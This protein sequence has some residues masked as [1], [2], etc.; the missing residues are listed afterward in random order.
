MAA[1]LIVSL[2]VP[3]AFGQ[4][5]V[6]FGVAYFV[7]R[8]LLLALYA[9]AA[10]GDPQLRRT[11]LRIVPA[12]TLGPGL[13]VISQECSTARFNSWSGALRS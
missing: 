8:A 11:V 7:V 12:G 3:G 2:S 5:G 1:M 9:V 4:D 13:V 6:V 10:R